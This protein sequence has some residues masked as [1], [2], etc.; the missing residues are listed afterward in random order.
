MKGEKGT[1]MEYEIEELLPIVAKLTDQYT[2]MESSSVPYETARIFMEAVIYCI[3]ECF[4]SEQE[5]AI[6]GIKKPDVLLLYERG[7]K[8]VIE[9]A[10]EAKKWYEQ[11][12][13]DFEDYGCRNYKDTILKGIP[14][15]FRGYDAKFNPQNH[16]LTLDYPLLT[17]NPS[18]CGV[19]LI[20]EY[21]KG[22]WVEKQLL[23]CFDRQ[24]VRHL[25]EK[26]L[27]E[28]SSLY[29]DNL[30][31]PILLNSVGC[32]IAEKPIKNM[33]LREADYKEIKRFFVGDN[34]EV[35]EEKIKGLIRM[36]VKRLP[37]RTAMAYFE[38]V[39]PNYAARILNG[40]QYDS[41]E[42]VVVALP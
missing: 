24:T 36:M 6:S 17:G 8:I 30:C 22:I 28:Y 27:P 39:A 41:L 12:I 35:A 7:C 18:L 34:Q 37:D 42:Y 11:I 13:V 33:E 23:D 2:S 32:I 21:L 25:M 29:L 19:N 20:L 14:E 38:K 31:Y 15:F 4:Q 26:N 5:Q 9:K 16:L 10:H 40:I 3:E 1:D